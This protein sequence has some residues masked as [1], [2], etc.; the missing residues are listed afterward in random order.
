MSLKNVC[1]AKNVSKSAFYRHKCPG[2]TPTLRP[3]NNYHGQD[4]FEAI[5]LFLTIKSLHIH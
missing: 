3:E 4:F 1:K 2:G 5:I